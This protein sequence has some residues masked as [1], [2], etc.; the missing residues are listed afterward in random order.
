MN[1][2]KESL[3][4]TKGSCLTF[5]LIDLEHEFENAIMRFLKGYDCGDLACCGYSFVERTKKILN[6][7][8]R[9]YTLRV[10]EQY[11]EYFNK[12]YLNAEQAEAVIE[13]MLY[14]LDMMDEDYVEK[15]LYGKNVYDDD[16]DTE[17]YTIEKAQRIFAVMDQNKES[18]M[19]LFNMFFWDLY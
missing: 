5:K 7:S 18:F 1:F 6:N 13:T 15:V 17:G 8:K 12:D 19:K 4:R 16:Y 10:P 11:K 9:A 3:K 14:H 2:I